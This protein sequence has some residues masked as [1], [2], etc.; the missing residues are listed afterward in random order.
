V[1][2]TNRWPEEKQKKK[3]NWQGT[4][5]TVGRQS[6]GTIS[7]FRGEKKE[8]EANRKKKTRGWVKKTH[9]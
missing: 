9:A 8:G 1:P 6:S 4:N 3:L 2:S 5:W 7:L